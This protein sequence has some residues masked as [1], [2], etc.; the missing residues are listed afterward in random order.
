[1]TTRHPGPAGGSHDRSEGRHGQ[2]AGTCLLCR[3]PGRAVAVFGITVQAD[4][5]R[6]LRSGLLEDVQTAADIP[7][8][9]MPSPLPFGQ[10]VGVLR[11]V[12]LDKHRGII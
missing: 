6:H 3:V 9:R 10:D 12:V 1:M 4:E 11:S 2:L 5:P 7:D 8:G